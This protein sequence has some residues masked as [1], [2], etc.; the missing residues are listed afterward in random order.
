MLWGVLQPDSGCRERGCYRCGLRCGLRG[1]RCRVVE[2][3][4]A[5]GVPPAHAAVPAPKVPRALAWLAVLIETEDAD[6]RG[7]AL[8]AVSTGV[9]LDEGIARDARAVG[10]APVLPQ[11]LAAVAPRAMVTNLTR[12]VLAHVTGAARGVSFARALAAIT[13]ALAQDAAAAAGERCEAPPT[14]AVNPGGRHVGGAGRNAGA[15]E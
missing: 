3:D 15:A 10:T 4:V 7:A 5:A 14:K 6:E 11:I 9:V 13:N 12:T 8:P 2:A 1:R